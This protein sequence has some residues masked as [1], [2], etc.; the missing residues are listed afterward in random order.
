MWAAAN[1]RN[2]VRATSP[3][4]ACPKGDRVMMDPITR[5]DLYWKESAKHSD[6]AKNASTPFLRSYYQRIAERY[7]T[8]E[9]ELRRPESEA[10]SIGPR[11]GAPHLPSSWG[12]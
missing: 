8:S 11:A 1:L 10:R 5:A 6:L 4:D 2:G 12:E 7:L 9:G 3:A